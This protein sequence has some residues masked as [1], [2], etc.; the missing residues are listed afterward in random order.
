MRVKDNG[1]GIDPAVAEK[2]KDGHFGLKGMR[3]RAFRIGGKLIIASS[4]NSGTEVTVVVPGRVVF[5]KAGTIDSK[6]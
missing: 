1:V 5:R 2:G 6:E 3:E 4:A